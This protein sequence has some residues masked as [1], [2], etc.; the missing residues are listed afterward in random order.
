MNDVAADPN[1]EAKR[2]AFRDALNRARQANMALAA[3]TTDDPAEEMAR[4]HAIALEAMQELL[5]ALARGDIEGI[6]RAL[7]KLNDAINKEIIMAK[8][9]A[10]KTDD[11]AKTD[12]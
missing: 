4:Q 2:K 6:A 10:A 1:N 5:D 3:A 12:K 11:K 7:K 9:I 8:A